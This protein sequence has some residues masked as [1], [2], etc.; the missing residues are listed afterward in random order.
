MKGSVN[1]PC[2]VDA[3]ILAGAPNTGG[4][5]EVSNEKYEAFVEINGIPLLEYVLKGVLESQYI[6]RVAV[7][8]PLSEP[9]VPKSNALAL[10]DDITWLKCGETL[11]EN[12][13]I[14][15]NSLP[16][17]KSVITFTADIPFINGSVVDNWI[18]EC[19]KVP[20][21]AYYPLIPKDVSEKAFPGCKRTYFNL[22]EGSFTGGNVFIFDAILAQENEEKITKIF[23]MRKNPLEMASML[24]PA[25]V[26]KFMTGKLSI[27]DTENRVKE[28]FDIVGKAMICPYAEIGMDVDKE[29]DVVIAERLLPTF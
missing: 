16:K 11:V 27:S 29:A 6:E 18:C 25:M 4:L 12:V 24:G 2:K 15:L 20:A 5:S 19:E 17:D 8:S 1:M 9:I 28:L 26:F 7:I 22:K 23:N 3:L 21:G 10:R 13:M 14:G